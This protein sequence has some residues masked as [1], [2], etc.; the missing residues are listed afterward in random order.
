M[1]LERLQ[2]RDDLGAHERA[3]C[4]L[5]VPFLGI[6]LRQD[7]MPIFILT[8]EAVVNTSNERRQFHKA[9]TATRRCATAYVSS[10]LE[11]YWSPGGHGRS[12][13]RRFA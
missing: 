10:S 13:S 12:R 4:G 6:H 3:S 1:Q 9:Q 5:S 8:I 2:P 7:A 11:V